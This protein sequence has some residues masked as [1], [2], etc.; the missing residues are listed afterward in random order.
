MSG[1]GFHCSG[2]GPHRKQ[3]G[4]VF[5]VIELSSR[6]KE[7]NWVHI[8]PTFGCLPAICYTLCLVYSAF[9]DSLPLFKLCLGVFTVLLV[10]QFTEKNKENHS[11][12]CTCKCG[13][14]SEGVLLTV[15]F[16]SGWFSKF[17]LI[18]VCL[19][20]TSTQIVEANVA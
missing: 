8:F 20:L 2:K 3:P 4:V 13:D 18:D 10:E 16:A 5:K 6:K 17:V 19:L 1:V 15:V 9:L 7:S 14:I 12:G 11:G